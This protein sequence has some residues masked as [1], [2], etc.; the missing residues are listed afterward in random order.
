MEMPV[1]FS[2]GL[3]TRWEK[4]KLLITSN[5]SFSHTVFKRLVVQTRKNLGL[6]GKCIKSSFDTAG[7]VCK[8]KKGD[9]E[10]TENSMHVRKGWGG[11]LSTVCI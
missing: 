7:H 3:K 8:K 2:K 11:K 6:F 10:Q 1:S 5:F 9:G 4:E